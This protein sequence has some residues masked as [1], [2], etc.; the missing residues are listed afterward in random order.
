MKPFIF[1]IYSILGISTFSSLNAQTPTLVE[2][3]SGFSFPT[4]IVCNGVDSGLYITGLAGGIRYIP[5]L[6]IDSSIIIGTIPNVINSGE[7]GLYGIA[8]HPLFPDSNYIYVHYTYDTSS[9]Q[10]RLSRFSIKNKELDTLSE[11]VIATFEDDLGIH[12]G[13]NPVFGN[14]GFLYLPRG[15]GDSNVGTKLNAQNPLNSKG[16]LLRLDINADDFPNDSLRNY[17]IPLDN[18]FVD[19]ISVIDEIYAFGLR[20]PWRMSIDKTTDEIYIGD[21]GWFS[22]EEINI[23]EKGDNLGWSCYE[24][25]LR[26]IGH[27]CYNDS[28]ENLKEAI[29]NGT[30]EHFSSIT[31]GK[32]YRGTK[33]P[34]WQG[35]YFFGDFVTK[36]LCIYENSEVHCW[37]NSISN[38]NQNIV[39]FGQDINN[40]IYLAD[41][42]TGQIHR[43]DTL[44]I[45]CSMIPDSLNLTYITNPIYEA[46]EYLSVD[47][48]I[49]SDVS[50]YA[51]EIILMDSVA[52][53]QGSNLNIFADFAL[54][55][56]QKFGKVY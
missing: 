37:D 46:N 16:S 12:Q 13:G 1:F 8:F 18:P 31:G 56:S 15:D 52:V 21:V 36:K 5:D 23:V 51:S 28:D 27:P 38:V 10:I 20:N 39:C 42:F 47:T 54:C 55:N 22:F 34:T 41:Y 33:Y 2:A 17:R 29:F 24:G 50:L 45:D 32:V 53:N 44:D 3:F 11:R 49:G 4:D 48:I 25:P 14:D 9:F 26:H 40:E 35:K 30:R 6:D 19:S 7:Q 43:I